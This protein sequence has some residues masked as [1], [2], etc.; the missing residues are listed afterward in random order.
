MRWCDT[1]INA[2]KT[3]HFLN[4]RGTIWQKARCFELFWIYPGFW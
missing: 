2:E 4:R 1:E 3:E